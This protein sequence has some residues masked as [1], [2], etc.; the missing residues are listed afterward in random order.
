MH[1]TSR[2]A[3]ASATVESLFAGR[4]RRPFVAFY[5]D[6]AEPSGMGE[7]MLTLADEVSRAE[8]A[9]SRSGRGVDVAFVCHDGERVREFAEAARRRGHEANVLPEGAAAWRALSAWLA[10]RR[11]DLLHVHAGVGWEG[12]AAPGLA[13]RAGVPAVLRTEHLPWVVA[14][15]AQV[16]DYR[17]H[18][19]DVDARLC[20]SEA[21][22]LSYAA[23]G[24]G[25]Q[26]P[27]SVVR[28]G[29]APGRRPAWTREAGRLAL[30]LRPE[31][32]AVLTVARFTR[33]K[34][35]DVL[36]EAA[37]AVLAEAPE[38]VF[39]WVGDGPDR[40]E[41][42]RR[43]AE[44]GLGRAVRFL[45]ARAD[46]PEL[47][48]ASDLF[49]LPSRFEGLPLALLEAMQAGLP[50][51]ATLAPGTAEIFEH[52]QA[53]EVVPVDDAP[54]LARAILRVLRDRDLADEL[55]DRGQRL[56]RRRFSA[57]RMGEE[58]LTLYRR[59]LGAAPVRAVP[60]LQ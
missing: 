45:G 29:I 44:A 54:A 5:T 47:T 19:A 34:G 51:V 8:A 9:G 2:N 31:Q 60:V 58:T 55:I 27:V 7:H 4:R 23:A 22:R 26:A 42:E 14:D 43:A 21:S 24:C 52:D 3:A 17:A 49:V 48:A 36:L 1:A 39:L 53:A 35:H 25:G 30:G 46:V 57:R 6:S 13:R 59:L 56:V 10:A 32:R 41:L 40:A 37:R 12:L 15:D 20:V 11:P 28:N 38:A 16:E 18:L 33:Q 50:A